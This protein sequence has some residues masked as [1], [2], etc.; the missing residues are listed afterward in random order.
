MADTMMSFKSDELCRF[1]S[2]DEMR[3]KA[4]YIFAKDV[5]NPNVSKK[6]V[7]ANTETIIDDLAK[8]GWGVVD[9]R[10]QRANKR[11]NIHSFHMV[12]FQHP[13]LYITKDAED[14]TSTVDCYPR[15][16]LTTS[17]DG[18]KSF[19][20]MVGLFRLVCSNGLIV[21]TSNFANISIRHM[22]YTFEE[23]RGVVAKAVQAVSDNVGVMNEMQSIELTDEQKNDFALAALKIRKGRE[24]DE[25]FKVPDTEIADVLT[26]EREE[27]E[28]NDLWSVFNVL[29]EKIIKG[30]FSTTSDKNGRQRKA[31]AIKGLAKDI[32]INQKLFLEAM[33]YRMAV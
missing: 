6:Y 5:T 30:T 26:P 24:N 21:A 27:D 25:K 8:L 4:P 11:S 32:E 15:L 16:I 23:L 22:N 1:M 17:H 18:F 33:K 2:K 31:R 3:E 28:G 12:A 9:C 14:G 20:F 13:D 19:K 29:Q 7:F 10:Q